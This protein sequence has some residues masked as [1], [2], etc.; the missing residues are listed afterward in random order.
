MY[1]MD[2]CGGIKILYNKIIIDELCIVLQRSFMNNLVIGNGFDLRL[3]K[4]AEE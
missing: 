1:Y 3:Y 4:C 2:L